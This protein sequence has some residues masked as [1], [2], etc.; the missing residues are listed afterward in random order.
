VTSRQ[1][2]RCHQV[3]RPGAISAASSRL[4]K[5]TNAGT[6]C[7]F[8]SWFWSSCGLA[9]AVPAADDPRPG[10]RLILAVLGDEQPGGDVEGNADTGEQ[11]QRRD[12]DA[13][14][15]DVRVQVAAMPP[16][17]PA[18]ILSSAD[19][20]GWPVSGWSVV[21]A[22]RASAVVVFILQGCLRRWPPSIGITPVRTLVSPRR[23][24][25]HP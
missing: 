18:S 7:P 13:N 21:A 15:R 6:D 17:T 25:G 3:A 22:D 1:G 5:L 10:D 12:D 23:Y 19:R 24:R 2:S 4:S 8:Q 16:A 9:D 14:E 20:R 11:D